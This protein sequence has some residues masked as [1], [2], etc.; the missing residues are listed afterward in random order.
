MEEN[1][2]TGRPL[3]R[4]SMSGREQLSKYGVIGQCSFNSCDKLA[5]F[6]CSWEN[7]FTSEVGGCDELC[8][9]EH[10]NF[11]HGAKRPI[12]CVN[13]I[14]QRLFDKKINRVIKVLGILIMLLLVGF[15]VASFFVWR[16]KSEV[17]MSV[18]YATWDEAA[19]PFFNDAFSK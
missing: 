17:T 9:Y 11:P 1:P 6:R 8:C 15:V 5:Q 2:D 14:D 16:S 3:S 18:P 19:A 12:S 4:V 10:T 7:L 13:C